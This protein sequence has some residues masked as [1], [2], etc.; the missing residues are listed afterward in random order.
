M[1]WKKQSKLPAVTVGSVYR[2]M[3]H[4]NA[5]EQA[6]VVSIDVDD[7]GIPHVCF[8]MTYIRPYATE[9]EG[10]RV[11]ALSVFQQNY[12]LLQ[13]AATEPTVPPEPATVPEANE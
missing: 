11:L 10:M 9:P 2:R 8:K 12:E 7:A 4:F 13:P 6:E 1:F 3:R 5:E